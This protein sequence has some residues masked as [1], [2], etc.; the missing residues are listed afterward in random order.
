[1]AWLTQTCCSHCSAFSSASEAS[2][3]AEGSLST[4]LRETEMYGMCRGLVPPLTPA[5]L[6]HQSVCGVC[7]IAWW[8]QRGPASPSGF[9]ILPLPSG[10]R[11]HL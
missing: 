2:T 11:T 6:S 1:M 4:L 9:P 3:G 7:D 5:L 8:G 10:H